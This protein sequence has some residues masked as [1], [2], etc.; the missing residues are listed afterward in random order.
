MS[1]A[2]FQI[3]PGVDQT[4]TP[5]LNQAA[6]SSSQLIRF[7]PDRTLGAIVQKLGGW[8][9]FVSGGAIGSYVRALWAWEDTNAVSYL[10]IGAEGLAPAVITNAVGNGTTVT[11]TFSTAVNFIT[12]YGITVSGVTPSAYNGNWIITGQTTTT[13]VTVTSTATGTYVSGGLISGT[14]RTLLYSRQN[15]GNPTIGD[16]PV[17]ITPQSITADATVNFATQAV[18]PASNANQVVITI[19]N[20]NIDNYDTI[21]IQTQVS[22]GGLILFG[23]YQCYALTSNSFYI[24]A[25]SPATSISS[26]ASVALYSAATINST[27]IG[28]TLPNHG[29]QVGDTYTSLVATRVG[30]TT[31]TNG[32]VIYGNYSVISLDGASP[33]DIF[34]I[35]ASSTVAATATNV[36][37]NGGLLRYTLYNGIGPLGAITGYGTGAYGGGGYGTG[38]VITSQNAGT[39]INATDWCLDNWGQIL[40]AN[41]YEGPIY[42]WDPT[43]N[44]QTATIIPEAPPVNQGV[45]VAMPQRQIIAW[46]TTYTGIVDPLQI[47]WCD[48]ENYNAWEITPTNQAGGYRIPKGSRIVQ[49]IQGPQQG[50]IWT[51]L[52]LW[53]MQYVGLPYVYQFNEIGVGCGLI[54]RKAAGSVNGIVYWM[55]Q[56][57]FF[58][59][60]GSGP[61]PIKCPVWDVIFQ[62]L[63]MTNTGKIRF[64]ANS[65]F[66][67]VSWYYPTKESNGEVAAYVKYNFLLDAWDYGALG[68]TAWIN[69]SVLGPPIG[70]GTDT[71][72]Y[73]HE[74]SPDAGTSAMNSSFQTGYFAMSEADV[75]MFVDQIWPDMKWGYYNQTQGA[76]VYLT[77]YTTDYAG[78]APTAEEQPATK[79]G[80]FLMT[81]ATQFITP[82]MRGRL[83]SMKL[84]SSDYGSFWRLGNI[85]YRVQQDGKY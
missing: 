62:D 35:N 27:Q 81:Q 37:Q 13:S 30:N 70:A 11:F 44:S 78:T 6:I 39:P 79:Y 85:R 76:N 25:A 38:T 45:F 53:A 75:K 80:P 9:Q 43:T 32:A 59:L 63:D 12:G 68:R 48:V 57:Q 69:E 77:F 10:G 17:D 19:A 3:L 16:Y 34:Y 41:P 20:S 83:V 84:E 24:Y 18:S 28:V 56:S 8:Q 14:G 72:I 54:G 50:L 67:E 42:T 73:Q 26:V 55:G 49:C 82:R 22:V 61:E 33:N 29:F 58:R 64:A 65:R 31:S 23:Q 5:A 71:V 21:Y 47:R 74:T 60:G 40:I 2:A 46:G 51:D 15:S 4:K 36:P 1:H 66:G 7:M 52:G